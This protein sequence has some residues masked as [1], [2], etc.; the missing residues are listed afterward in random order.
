MELPVAA[1]PRARM[2]AE[3]GEE[4][5][6]AAE[7]GEN[8]SPEVAGAGGGEPEENNFCD[9]PGSY[10]VNWF[11]KRRK[12]PTSVAANYP[13]RADSPSPSPFREW[14][15]VASLHSPSQCHL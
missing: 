3:R 5:T 14:A 11:G 9:L 10:A 4:F 7:W 6:G 2:A 12:G 15:P 1:S 8:Q 13:S